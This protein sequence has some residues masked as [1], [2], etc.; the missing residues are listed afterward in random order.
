VFA[1]VWTLFFSREA[2]DA[3]ED[4]AR[5]AAAREVIAARRI[6]KGIGAAREGY[7]LCEG[8][9]LERQQGWGPARPCVC[10]R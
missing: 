1:V 8:C 7:D 4:D 10:G 2:R 5:R 6:Q 9:D 3:R